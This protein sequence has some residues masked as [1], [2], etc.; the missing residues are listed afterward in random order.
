MVSRRRGAHVAHDLPTKLDV[1]VREEIRFYLEMR[2]GELVEAGLSPDEALRAALAAFGDTD[3]VAA[4]C[5]A[6]NAPAMRSGGWREFMYR[7]GQDLRY[8]WRIV[9]RNPSFTA[10]VVL[11][12]G[13]GIGGNAAIFSVVNGVLIR[14]LPYHEPD[15]VVHLLGTQRGV[16]SRHVY[17]SYPAFTEWRER[18]E[19]LVNVAAYGGWNPTMLGVGEPSRLAGAS[20]SANFFDVLAVQPALGRF[21]LPEEEELGHDPVVVLSYGL[22]QRRFGGDAGVIGRTLNLAG[23]PYTVVGVAG[24]DFESPLGQPRLWEARP[25]WWDETQLNRGNRSWRVIGRLKPGVSL[26]QAQA[27]MDVIAA[28]MGDEYPAFNTAEGVRLMTVKERMVGTARPAV[29]VLL[30]AVGLVLLIACANVANLLLSRSAVR[31]RELALRTALGAGRRRLLGQLLTESL[32]LSVAGGAL[33]LALAWSGTG[34]LVALGSAGIPRA[35]EIQVDG[36]VLLFTLGIS[37]FT[38]VLFGLVPAL[39]ATKADLTDALKEGGRGAVTSVR[40]QALRGGLVVAEIALSLV[41]L[42]GAGLLIRSLKN[43]ERVDAGLD[44]ENVLTMQIAPSREKHPGHR[45]LTRFYDDLTARLEG[46]PGVQ[47]AGAISFLP[48][49]GSFS[50][51]GV[52]RDDRP[53]E[54]QRDREGR[55]ICAEVRAV[56]VDYFRVMGMILVRGRGFTI[57]DDSGSTQVAVVN[58]ALARQQYPGEDPIGKRMTA[59]GTSREIVGIVRDVRQLNL[60]SGASMAFYSPQAQERQDW[61]RRWMTLALRTTVAPL[62]V[63]DMARRTV[64]EVD[65]SIPINRLRT[66]ESVVSANIAQPRFRTTLLAIFA[67]VALLLA[68][69]GIAGVMAYSVSQRVPEI[70]LRKALGAREHDISALVVRQ[71]LRLTFLGVALG[72]AGAFATTRLLSSL[73]FNVPATDFATFVGVTVLLGSIAILACYVPARRASRVDPMVALRLE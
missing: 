21:F 48:M 61:M 63:A 40:S 15:R 50:C 65:E 16:L 24:A 37:I 29:L 9:R 58:E 56:T 31:E 26:E 73:L 1:E 43:L 51:A 38:S 53:S 20:V 35:S 66:M 32:V 23:G 54:T 57:A 33:G 47:I 49:T 2:A 69:I 27:D 70:G 60:A 19:S 44:T 62:S 14:P 18:N 52:F 72:L 25:P 55:V 13:I 30:G 71:G 12:L 41:L 28:W 34:Y 46:I 3:A 7:V 64:W 6:I 17:M 45:D 67:S 59:N 36:T 39:Q 4:E 10:V 42:T 8:G 68:S 11:T 22:W 5:L